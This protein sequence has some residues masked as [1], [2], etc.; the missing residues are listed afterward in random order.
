MLCKRQWK[1]MKQSNKTWTIFSFEFLTRIKSKGFIISTILGPL[2]M[3]IIIVVPALVASL[4]MGE[5]SKYFAVLD[6]TG[7]IGKLLVAS[8]TSKFFLTSKKPAELKKEILNGKLDAYV[9]IPAN[10]LE[11]GKV[12]VYTP[13]GGGIGILETVQSKLQDIIMEKKLQAAN[14]DSSLI[15]FVKNGIDVSSVKVTEAGTEKDYTEFYSIF[16]YMLG[17]LIYGLMFAYGGIVMRGVIQEK[18]NRIVEILSSSA[19][20]MQIMM[21]KIFGIGA[22]GL[23]QILIWAVIIII[24]A[25]AGASILP[26]FFS[27]MN[28]PEMINGGGANAMQM[29][30]NLPFDIP[31]IPIGVWIGFLFFFLVGYFMYASLFAAIGSAVNQE[32]DAQQL[33]TPVT[34]ALIIPILFM[35][36]IMGN[37]DGSLATILSLIPPFTP[38]LMTARIAATTVPLWQILLSIALTL[39]T[40]FLV[41]WIAAKIYRIGILMYGKKPSFKDLIK[42][43]RLSE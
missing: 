32:E 5:T 28:S 25:I 19:R 10:I 30:G 11:T 14:A 15:N 34:L 22:V 3:L 29:Q 12:E 1:N 37:P 18:A 8:D 33:Q 7:D 17:I 40:L 2:V 23:F 35:P 4:T 36:V 24:L 43:L 21:G 39:A 16:G 26:M 42:W 13:G 9:H 27:G 31:A 6:D 38:I 20:P 41:I